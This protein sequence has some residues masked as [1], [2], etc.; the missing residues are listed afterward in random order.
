MAPKTH[1]TR[2]YHGN[3]KTTPGTTATP[4]IKMNQIQAAGFEL[5]SRGFI[6]VRILR[7]KYAFVKPEHKRR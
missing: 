5:F 3:N 1:G 7:M 2:K 4:I 6:S